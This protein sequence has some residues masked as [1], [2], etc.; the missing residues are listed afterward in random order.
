VVKGTAGAS[1]RCALQRT[2]FTMTFFS[3][4]G[5]A[6]CADRRAHEAAR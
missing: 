6:G 4:Q 5:S 2:F 1:D 3:G